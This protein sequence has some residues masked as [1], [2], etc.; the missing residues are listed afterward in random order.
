MRVD[1]DPSTY[2][3]ES[4][5]QQNAMLEGNPDVM[6]QVDP[7]SSR[8][9]LSYAT[10]NMASYEQNQLMADTRNTRRGVRRG[11]DPDDEG[12]VSDEE[13]EGKYN[14]DDDRLFDQDDEGELN[15]R[16]RVELELEMES[17][18]NLGRWSGDNRSRL[19]D[20][21]RAA[22]NKKDA[23]S[24]RDSAFLNSL[25]SKPIPW[26]RPSRTYQNN[27]VGLIRNSNRS[28]QLAVGQLIP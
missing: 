22:R 2:P 24:M 21:Q 1:P 11:Q 14:R 27:S 13:E 20:F 19:N 8:G 17:S 7:E 23:D 18:R 3:E 25:R 28:M 12:D 9:N 5:L 26:E 16:E 15:N 6:P 4:L 10:T